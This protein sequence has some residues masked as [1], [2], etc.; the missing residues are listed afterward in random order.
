ME[1][2][3][4]KGVYKG[5]EKQVNDA[6]IR[7]LASDGVSKARIARDFGVSR[8]TVY[9]ALEAGRAEADTEIQ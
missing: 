5:R 4:S 8:M 2:A 6:R 9:R 3:K 7:K 1:A